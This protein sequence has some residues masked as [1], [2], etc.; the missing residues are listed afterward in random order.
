MS[1]EAQRQAEELVARWRSS[2]GG[3]NP[4]GPLFTSGEHAEADILGAIGPAFTP[5][6]TTCTRSRRRHCC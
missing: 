2:A 6:G 5:C 4:A 1:E 3:D